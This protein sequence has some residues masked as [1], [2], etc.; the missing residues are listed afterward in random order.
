MK[1]IYKNQKNGE[2]IEC[3]EPQEDLEQDEDWE[4]VC[5]WKDT[6]LKNNK[7]KKLR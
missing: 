4:L 5:A 2:Q 3:D 1:Y 7:I 6:K